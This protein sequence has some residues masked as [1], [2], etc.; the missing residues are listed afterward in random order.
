MYE[1]YV[2]CVQYRCTP[3]TV[4]IVMCILTPRCS[5]NKTRLVD[6]FRDTILIRNAK[7]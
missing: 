7:R 1:K 4:M 6:V 5:Q 2:S 3:S